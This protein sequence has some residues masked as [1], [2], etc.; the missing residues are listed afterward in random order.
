MQKRTVLVVIGIIIALSPFA[1]LPYSALMWLLP[2]LGIITAVLAYPFRARPRA[3]ASDAPHE[4][5]PGI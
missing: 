5:T 4:T 1:G 3:V 2:I